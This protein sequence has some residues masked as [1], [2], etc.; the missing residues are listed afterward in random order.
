MTV[1]I[2]WVTDIHA[3]DKPSGT[4]RINVSAETLVSDSQSKC[5]E[6]IGNVRVTQGNTVITSDKLRIFYKE[7]SETGIKKIVADGNVKIK[8][9][10]KTA[11]TNQAVYTTDDEILILSGDGS[12]VTTGKDSV[13]GSK[14]ILYRAEG[15]V[16]VEGNSDKP[17]EA[18]IYPGDKGIIKND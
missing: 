12:K 3:G 5:A 2:M 16:K 7:K 9:D 6:F 18:V 14:I 13:S 15:R 17:V 4:E 8:F 11:E 10:D 1:F